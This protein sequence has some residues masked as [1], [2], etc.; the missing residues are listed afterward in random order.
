VTRSGSAHRG[1]KRSSS[2]VLAT[3]LGDEGGLR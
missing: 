2:T 1:R 3:V